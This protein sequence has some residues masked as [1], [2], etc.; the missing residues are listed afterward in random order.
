MGAALSAGR[1]VVELAPASSTQRPPDDL[2]WLLAALITRCLDLSAFIRLP[3]GTSKN[4]TAPSSPP[5][6]VRLQGHRGSLTGWGWPVAQPALRRCA[7]PATGSPG[8]REEILTHF[9]PLAVCPLDLCH[10]RELEQ[11]L[12]R[13][14]YI[15]NFTFDLS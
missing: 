8:V 14:D 13:W 11:N 5:P 1:A 15:L 2:H 4:H 3:P 10:A 9:V 7:S 12:T 6:L